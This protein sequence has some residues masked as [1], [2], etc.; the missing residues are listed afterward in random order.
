MKWS[1]LALAGFVIAL[2]AA[3]ALFVGGFGYNHGW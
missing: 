2:G 1:P 3:A